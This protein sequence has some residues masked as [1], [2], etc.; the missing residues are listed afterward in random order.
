ML[1]MAE[2]LLNDAAGGYP[3]AHL[4]D[5]LTMPQ[6]KRN[7]E[8]L[9]PRI[10][11]LLDRALLADSGTLVIGQI[12]PLVRRRAASIGDDAR[13]RR[14]S[15]V[16]VK[17]HLSDADRAVDGLVIRTHLN[18]AASLARRLNVP[19]LESLAVSRLQSAP[20]VEWKVISTNFNIPNAFIRNYLRP[21]KRV[22]T[23]TKALGVW[24]D[25]DSPSGSLASN[26][27][28]ARGVLNRS[29]FARLATT[30]VFGPSDLPKRLISED[31]A[32]LHLPQLHAHFS[33]EG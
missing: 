12:A 11:D 1:D 24:F 33:G 21:Y 10:D 6:G 7:T 31:V 25:S 28:V 13:V 23:W 16:E 32:A 18:D 14:A 17:A 2:L 27:A 3:L 5:A 20:P 15:E 30:V 26:E 9:D 8:L 19:E 29:V 4:L 22:D